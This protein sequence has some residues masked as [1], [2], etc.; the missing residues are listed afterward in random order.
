VPIGARVPTKN[1]NRFEIDPQPEP[2]Q[3]SWAKLSITA[4]GSD[5]GIVDAEIIRPRSWIL[6]SGL[7]A[8]RMLPL[9][10]PELEVSGLVLSVS[11]SRVSQPIYNIEVQGEH[12]YQV[13]ELGVVVHNTRPVKGLGDIGSHLPMASRDA[14]KHGI[15]WLGAGY[16]EI[17]PGVFRSADGLRQFRMMAADLLGFHGKVGPHVHIEALDKFGKVIGNLHLL[18]S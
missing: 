6:A 16:K 3:A 5:G 1:P 2:D 8:G 18:I 4:E 17:A 9:N 10:L 7:C 11:L 15:K 14:L 13:G 12:V